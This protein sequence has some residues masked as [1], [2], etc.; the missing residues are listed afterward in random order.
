MQVKRNKPN[1]F[2]FYVLDPCTTFFFLHEPIRLSGATTSF[3][4][5]LYCKG[6]MSERF[7]GF[8]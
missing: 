5:K 6:N 1:N 3:L 7:N 2:I 4:G 8:Y